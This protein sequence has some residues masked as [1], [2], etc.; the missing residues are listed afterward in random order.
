M[1]VKI[2]KEIIYKTLITAAVFWI[3]DF[4][5]HYTGVGESNYYY[6]LKLVNSFI[7]AFIWF[8]VFDI[9]KSL[10]KLYFSI[11]FGTWV[12]FS[13][14][15]SSYSGLVQ[16]FGVAA[17]YSPPPFVIF[18]VFLTPFLWWVFHILA[19]YAGLEVCRILEK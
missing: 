7:F 2:T 1:K 12:S 8:A 11:V 18:G 10:R 13:Y 19:F 17:R 14:L 16:F 6:S 5:M 4:V 3:L 15:I 9:K